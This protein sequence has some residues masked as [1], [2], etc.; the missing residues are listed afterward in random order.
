MRVIVATWLPSRQSRVDLTGPV[1]AM[2]PLSL[3][4]A[5]PPEVLS[6]DDGNRDDSMDGNK[7]DS[8]GGSTDGNK[9]GSRGGSTDGSMDNSSRHFA[10]GKAVTNVQ[11]KGMKV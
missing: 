5:R 10:L 7:D 1:A 9:G 4:V 11:G 6:R 8:R 2:R 3:G